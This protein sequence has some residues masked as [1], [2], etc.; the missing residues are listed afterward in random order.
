MDTSSS[1]QMSYEDS[2]I[3]QELEYHKNFSNCEVELI[4]TPRGGKNLI[5]EDQ[6]FR[7]DKN[8][9]TQPRIIA[10]WQNITQESE[11]MK[12]KL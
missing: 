10:P 11:S 1:L 6:V 2:S 8:S 12:I 5:L 7:I 4:T 3:N 9:K